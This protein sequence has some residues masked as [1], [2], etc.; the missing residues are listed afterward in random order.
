MLALCLTLAP[1]MSNA[2][3]SLDLPGR[4]SEQMVTQPGRGKIPVY[5][6]SRL[7]VELGGSE[8]E[9]LSKDMLVRRLFIDENMA[10]VEKNHHSR[11]PDA[12]SGRK[13]LMA[14]KIAVGDVLQPAPDRSCSYNFF[15]S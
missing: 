11:A 5:A 7:Q 12:P 13:T 14:M 10:P 15:S 8:E 2:E 1:L 4:L 6:I 3:P 9:R